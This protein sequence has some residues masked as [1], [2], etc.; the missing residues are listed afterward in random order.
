MATKKPKTK[1]AFSLELW[2]VPPDLSLL[3]R[4]RLVNT[5][6]GLGIFIDS[7][8]PNIAVVRTFDDRLYRFRQ[9]QLSLF[10]VFDL[11]N[12][13]A[14]LP[15]AYTRYLK[16]I[17]RE[18]CK[19]CGGL[20]VPGSGRCPCTSV[21]PRYRPA[22]QGSAEAA[23]FYQLKKSIKSGSWSKTG[24][25]APVNPEKR[26]RRAQVTQADSRGFGLEYFPVV[27]YSSANIRKF[28]GS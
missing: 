16:K 27:G 20:R 13:G 2:E 15:Q 18:Q 28:P 10:A 21:K 19:R 26:E 7:V 4:P 11:V 12:D 5:I 23:H 24:Y 3:P 9:D 22:K 25:R 14:E 1:L 6:A 8:G 17:R